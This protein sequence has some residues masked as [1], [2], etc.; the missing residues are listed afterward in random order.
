MGEEIAYVVAGSFVGFLI[1]RHGL[2]LFR[3]LYEK[4]SYEQVYGKSL[5][6]LEK[7]WRVSLQGK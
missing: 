1:E 2:P 7:E 6:D 4:D 3:S 5:D